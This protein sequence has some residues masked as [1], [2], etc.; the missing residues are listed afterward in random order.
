V[1]VD[2]NNWKDMS[3]MK[4]IKKKSKQR[5]SEYGFTL[6]ETAMASMIILVGLVSVSNLFVLAILNNQSSKQTTIATSIAKRKME[7][8]LSLPLTGPGSDQLAY[9][10]SISGTGVITPDPGKSQNYYVDFDR[11]DQ[12][13][14][15]IIK[16]TGRIQVADASLPNG[17]GFYPNQPVTYR[18][19][20]V[21]LPDNVI[22]GGLPS[23]PRLR[24]ITVRAV[25]LRGATLGTSAAPEEAVICTIRTPST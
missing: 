11:K 19:D 13:N 1:E 7:N 17:G 2:L 23:L 10:G 8:L 9:S 20:W 6:L 18:V 25:A 16:G 3:L 21:V 5:L 15:I 14:G 22:T 24:R 12:V 4:K